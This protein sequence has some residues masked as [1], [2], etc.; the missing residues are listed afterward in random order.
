MIQSGRYKKIMVIGADKMS[1]MV[2]YQD[3]ATCVLFGDGAGAVLVEGTEEEGVGVQNSFFRTDGKVLQ[4]IS[5]STIACI[6]SIRKGAQCSAL[7]SPL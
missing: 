3:R 4:A 6:I 7:P 1:S 2:D 5:Q